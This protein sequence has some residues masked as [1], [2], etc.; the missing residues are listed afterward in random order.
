MTN[1]APLPKA[2]S[3]PFDHTGAYC[4]AD[5]IQYIKFKIENLSE[6]ADLDALGLYQKKGRDGIIY[7]HHIELKNVECENIPKGS[8]VYIESQK[9]DVKIYDD[10]HHRNVGSLYRSRSAKG[11]AL[12]AADFVEM[13]WNGEGGGVYGDFQTVAGAPSTGAENKK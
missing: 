11:V 13:Q 4:R 8:F 5:Y 3:L 1:S 9:M 6:G 12:P 10:C 7:G 2:S